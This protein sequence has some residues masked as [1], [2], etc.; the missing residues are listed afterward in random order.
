MDKLSKKG[1]VPKTL[2]LSNVKADFDAQIG[3][4]GFGGIFKGEYGRQPVA[5]KVIYTPRHKEVNI[6]YLHRFRC[7]DACLAPFQKDSI[8]STLCREALAWRSLSHQFI[9]PLL[10]IYERKSQLYLVSPYMT[11]GT[12]IQWREKEWPGIPE[13][14]R[15]VRLLRS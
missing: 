14:Y 8:E 3:R 7:S 13:I 12:L 15:V 9:I 4:G 11:N 2:F 10:G 1:I 5:L 6:V